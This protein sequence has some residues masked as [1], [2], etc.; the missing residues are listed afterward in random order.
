MTLTAPYELADDTIVE[1]AAP[2][3][4]PA[5]VPPPPGKPGLNA[6]TIGLCALFLSLFA[7]VGAIVAISLAARAVHEADDRPAAAAVAAAPGP[8]QATL[9]LTE[10]T[11]DPAPVKLGTGGGV[12]RIT[13]VGNVTHNVLVD[14]R[15]SKDLAAGESTTMDLTGIADGQ[16]TLICAVPGH[17]SSGMKTTL[18]VG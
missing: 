11:I 7:F 13:N 5:L 6:S 15:Q 14:D 16:Y 4:A 9:T 10:F 1:P 18:I 2:A 8:K 3:S 12:L 17:E